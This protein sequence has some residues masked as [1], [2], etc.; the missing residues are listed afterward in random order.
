MGPKLLA[1]RGKTS[2]RLR[3][4]AVVAA[5]AATFVWCAC[6]PLTPNAK[7]LFAPDVRT[8]RPVKEQT[9][10]NSWLYPNDSCST[11]AVVEPTA[12]ATAA[13]VGA[14]PVGVST[15]T[16]TVSQA[17]RYAR[18]IETEYRGA[19]AEYG[20]LA[21]SFGIIAIPAAA[22]ALALTAEDASATAATALGFGTAALIGEG[23]WLSNRPREKVYMTG[24]NALECLISTMQPFDVEQTDFCTYCK[25][26]GDCELVRAPQCQ[27]GP[28]GGMIGSRDEAQKAAEVLAGAI[29]QVKND[30]E[31]A[32]DKKH[33]R[34]YLCYAEQALKAARASDQAAAKAYDA[35]V[36]YQQYST[37]YAGNAMVSTANTINNKVS[38]A[39]IDS[40]PDLSKLA[41]NLKGA[42]ADTA[43]PLTQIGSAKADAQA[44]S[45]AASSAAQQADKRNPVPTAVSTKGGPC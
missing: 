31:L 13:S 22:S 4:V 27:A 21:T 26:V 28:D 2:H 38:E 15:P 39:M 42:M 41:S 6:A 30:R 16:I 17:T 10:L 20:S 29:T 25:T 9:T 35:A 32:K 36:K 8:C 43:V 1:V 3:Q 11:Y 14:T 45:S 18:Q 37:R 40:E 34:P 24:A 5:L 33:F 7:Y 19:K 23:E 12:T 44:A